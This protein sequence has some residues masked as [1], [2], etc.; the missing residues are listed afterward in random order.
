MIENEPMRVVGR[1]HVALPSLLPS[2]A[3]LQQA[4]VHQAT[5]LSM[6]PLATCGV[7]KGVYRFI[8]HEAAN[9]A[10]DDALCVATPLGVRGTY[11]LSCLN[12]AEK[13]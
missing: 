12:V 8:T 4:A 6:M 13:M 10:S 5:A 9:R 2:A 1:K 3:A 11:S 7:R